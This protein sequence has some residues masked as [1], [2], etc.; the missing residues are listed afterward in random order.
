MEVQML[1]K[2]MLCTNTVMHCAVTC[3]EVF[4]K[5]KNSRNIA[6]EN[7]AFFVHDALDTDLQHTN[8]GSELHIYNRTLRKLFGCWWENAVSY[9]LATDAVVSVFVLVVSVVH[10][11]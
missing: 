3:K 2:V 11:S 9:H 4:L 8:T 10:F 5:L 7:S 1:L 6:I